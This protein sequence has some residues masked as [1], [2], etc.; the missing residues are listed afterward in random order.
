MR[1]LPKYEYTPVRP[2]EQLYSRS[3]LAELARVP[4]EVVAFWGRE[5]IIIHAE[6]GDG[7]GSHKKYDFAQVNI[8]AILGSIRRQFAPKTEVLK[9]LAER[10]QL[11]VRLI[12]SSNLYYLNAERA[13]ALAS[14]LDGY[15]RGELVE[16]YDHSLTEGLS[17]RQRL[18]VSP[19][20]PATDELEIVVHYCDHSDY[21]T[22]S[23]ILA[24]AKRMEPGQE[25][26]IRLGVAIFGTFLTASNL[27]NICWIVRPT[28]EGW[29]TLEISEGGTVDLTIR[30]AAFY[31]P[32]CSIIEDTWGEDWTL[33]AAKAQEM[34][35][36]RRELSRARRAIAQKGAE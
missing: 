32:V 2:P 7:R 14:A 36:V 11:A 16:V 21:D 8:A 12:S 9:S 20:R 15:R 18:E 29:E 1:Y 13:A 28:D 31:L 34:L 23:D 5:A 17:A 25:R 35:E 24:A 33:A 30:E 22:A 3:E 6:G 26:N 10:L 27:D 4:E 19:Y